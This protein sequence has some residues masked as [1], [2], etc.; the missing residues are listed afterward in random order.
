MAGRDKGSTV[1]WKLVSSLLKGRGT[2]ISTLFQNVRTASEMVGTTCKEQLAE[3]VPVLFPVFLL[4]P[5]SHHGA[6]AQTQPGDELAKTD[7]ETGAIGH[8]RQR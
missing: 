6:G 8:D 5:C 3:G 1:F 7:R 2:Q 4:S